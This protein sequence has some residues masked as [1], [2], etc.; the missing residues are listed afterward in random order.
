MIYYSLLSTF[1]RINPYASTVHGIEQTG[2]HGASK[3]ECTVEENMESLLLV[4]MAY[5]DNATAFRELITID[6]DRG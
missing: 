4:N 3:E 2:V 6:L 5:I 1:T